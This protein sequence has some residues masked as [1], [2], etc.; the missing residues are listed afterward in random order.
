MRKTMFSHSCEQWHFTRNDAVFLKYLFLKGFT[1]RND[2]E[3]LINLLCSR[4]KRLCKRPLHLHCKRH[5]VTFKTQWRSMG[6]WNKC[7]FRLHSVDD[8]FSKL[9]GQVDWVRSENTGKFLVRNLA[10][11]TNSIYCNS[12]HGALMN[13]FPVMIT[14]I[15]WREFPTIF[16]SDEIFHLLMYK[17]IYKPTHHR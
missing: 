15:G 9:Q 14:P 8:L 11:L 7:L 6:R 5:L 16:W 4:N 1:E 17:Y 10:A 3:V 2:L 12:Q 13:R